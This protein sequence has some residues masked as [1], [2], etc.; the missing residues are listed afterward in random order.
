M[1]EP[2]TTGSGSGLGDQLADRT[3]RPA[4]IEESPEQ[5]TL[6]ATN[7]TDSHFSGRSEDFEAW[8]AVHQTIGFLEMRRQQVDVSTARALRSLIDGLLKAAEVLNR[9]NSLDPWQRSTLA[10]LSGFLDVVGGT[11]AE[12]MLDMRGRLH[13]AFPWLEDL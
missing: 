6:A 13:R 4:E 12:R 8:Q 9:P 7:R 2:T 10:E 1:S 3:G 5:S 11:R